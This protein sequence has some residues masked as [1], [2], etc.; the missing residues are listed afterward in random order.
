VSI[1]QTAMN[2]QNMKLS[3]QKAI[4]RE[5]PV[6]GV[7]GTGVATSVAVAGGGAI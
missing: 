4:S 3:D 7:D 6:S 5:S 2:A 1:P